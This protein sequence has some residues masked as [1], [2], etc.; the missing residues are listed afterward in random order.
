[1]QRLRS[2]QEADIWI[3]GGYFIFRNRIFDFIREGEELVLEPFARLIEGGHLMAYRYEGFWRAMDTLRD[4][5][6]LEE[7]AERGDTP[8]RMS[9]QVRARAAS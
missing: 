9:T 8:W 6:L 3:N 1:V 4:R 2:S 7:M 5:Q